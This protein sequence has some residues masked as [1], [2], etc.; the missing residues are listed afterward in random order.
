LP[1]VILKIQC[2][3]SLYDDNSFHFFS[4][5]SGYNDFWLQFDPAAADKL[6]KQIIAINQKTEF[7]GHPRVGQAGMLE[8]DFEWRRVTIKSVGEETCSF[9]AVDRGY[10]KDDYPANMVNLPASL[11]KI[12]PFA[13]PCTLDTDV[14]DT[15]EEFQKQLL[16]KFFDKGCPIQAFFIAKKEHQLLVQLFN[17]EK[18]DFFESLK[19]RPE[20][21]LTPNKRQPLEVADA[22]HRAP[23]SFKQLQVIS[24]DCRLAHV[25]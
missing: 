5:C 11:A 21:S 19:M 8:F 18:E 3:Y 17:R 6:D 25:K 23:H 20:P 16:R 12:P 15:S 4:F 10:E 13:F 24:P 1:N 14:S 9:L 2:V 7:E 22:I